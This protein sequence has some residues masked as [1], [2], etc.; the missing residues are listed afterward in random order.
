L[1]LTALFRIGIKPISAL[2][3]KYFR[4]LDLFIV[5]LKFYLGVSSFLARP[6]KAEPWLSTRFAQNCAGCHAPGRKNLPPIDRRCTLSCQGCHVNPNG[7]GLRS[8][9]GKWN[10]NYWLKSFRIQPLN[11]Y[12]MFAPYPLISKKRT[13]WE[14]A[15]KKQRVFAVEQGFKLDTIESDFPSGKDYDRGSNAPYLTIADS[16]E[17]FE[18]QIPRSDPYRKMI[19]EKIDGGG[20]FRLIH[21]KDMTDSVTVGREKAWL[22]EGA[23]GLRYRPF[24]SSHIVYEALALGSPASQ[25]INSLPGSETTGSLYIMQDDLPY[26]IFVMSGFYRPLFGHT[27]AD[28]SALSQVMVS[29][30]LSGQSNR[31]RILHKAISIGT[32]PNV[33]YGNLHLIGGRKFP[34]SEDERGIAG[35]LG[36]RFV[37]LGA[38]INYSFWT[39]EEEKD[40]GTKK[41]IFH[42]LHFAATH[43]NLILSLE[44]I[45]LMTDQENEDLR[46]GGVY[47][48]EAKYRF[49][50]EIFATFDYSVANTNRDLLPGWVQQIKFG[51]RSFLSPGIEFLTQYSID[52]DEK[53]KQKSLSTV[54]HTYF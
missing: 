1:D 38:S 52:E 25:G 41:N 17:E 53:S 28:H 24:R 51:L 45:S 40:N 33:P 13:P 9:Y 5:L 36:L 49:F 44:G 46:E 32:A 7:G 23:F 35:N 39:T 20:D 26:N 11:Q 21:T 18:Y 10:E 31:Y 37:T 27:S 2:C 12:A 43:S 48:L 30:A 14:K 47:S 8:F 4:S 42:S 15:D 16:R 3:R 29:R 22:M 34:D 19:T 50:R 54:I 6:V